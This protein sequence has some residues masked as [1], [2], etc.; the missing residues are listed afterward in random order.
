[1]VK[2]LK[3]ILFLLLSTVFG[4]SISDEPVAWAAEDNVFA[5]QET[6]IE[7]WGMRVE[8]IASSESY[9]S[10]SQLP[11]M[12]DAEIENLGGAIQLLT[13]L[14]VQRSYT[15]EF[16]LSLKGVLI[17]MARHVGALSS[18]RLKLFDIS[19]FGQLRPACEYYVFALRHIII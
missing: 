4:G 8:V 13:F 1:M 16:L 18:Q 19:T 17:R 6:V 12:P 10:A 3:L 9:V 5:Y 7:E 11:Y 2:F 14:R 15:T